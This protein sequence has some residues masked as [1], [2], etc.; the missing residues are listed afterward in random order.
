MARKLVAFFSATGTTADVARRLAEAAGADLFEIAP[1]RAYT[2]PDLDW[3]DETARSTVEM[4]D[5]SC[6][7]ETDGAAVDVAAYDTIFVGFPIWWYREPSI[8]DTFLEAH[9]FSGKKLV[10]FATSG[11]SGL[12]ETASN[13]RELAPGADVDEG[14][15]FGREVSPEELATWSERF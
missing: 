12:G 2:A 13:F 1:A 11:G 15:I 14:R 4:K 8:V 5:R 6:R 9:D 3:R 10:P 7:P